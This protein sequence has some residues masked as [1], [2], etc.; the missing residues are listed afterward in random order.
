MNER[1]NEQDVDETMMDMNR[2]R[3]ADRIDCV[4]FV[5]SEM[6]RSRLYHL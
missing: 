6:G 1:R 3:S 5:G 2:L 4:Y